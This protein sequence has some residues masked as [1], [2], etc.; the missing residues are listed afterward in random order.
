M[1]TPTE[2]QIRAEEKEFKRVEKM[3]EKKDIKALN[4]H[5]KKWLRE[6]RK[7]EKRYNKK[8]KKDFFPFF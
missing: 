2:K 8:T 5:T 1:K 7:E 3:I 4:K 6:T